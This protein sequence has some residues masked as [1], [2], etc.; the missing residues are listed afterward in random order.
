MRVNGWRHAPTVLA[1]RKSRFCGSHDRYGQVPKNVTPNGIRSPDRPA[2]SKCLYLMSY[3]APKF[4]VTRK[5]IV[6]FA[7]QQQ[8]RGI[9]TKAK[10][11]TLFVSLFTPRCYIETDPRLRGFIAVW[12]R[13]Q[14]MVSL[15]RQI[16]SDRPVIFTRRFMLAIRFTSVRPRTNLSI[17]GLRIRTARNLSDTSRKTQLRLQ[18]LSLSSVKFETCTVYGGHGTTR[19]FR[20]GAG[21]CTGYKKRPN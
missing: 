9:P 12:W 20:Q 5:S 2:R 11:W 19:A 1:P 13:H 4:P 21:Y 3:H 18:V 15:L 7:I 14:S 16:N 8:L 10:K 17:I 6:G